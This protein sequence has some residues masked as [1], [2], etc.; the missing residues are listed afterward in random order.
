MTLHDTFSRRHV[1]QTTALASTSIPLVGTAAGTT[2]EVDT[3]MEAFAGGSPLVVARGDALGF[4][5]EHFSSGGS[6]PFL[7]RTRLRGPESFVALVPRRL[8]DEAGQVGLDNMLLMTS[9]QALEGNLTT[10]MAGVMYS[11]SQLISDQAGGAVSDKASPKLFPDELEATRVLAFPRSQ[12]VSPSNWSPEGYRGPDPTDSVEAGTSLAGLAAER[13]LV[14]AALGH[15]F[16][17]DDV[18]AAVEPM[19]WEE[20]AA[21]ETA[22]V[23][24]PGD[25]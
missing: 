25:L 15:Q 11:G 14:F 17:T 22:A 8:T 9:A 21:T 12:W 13:A 4:T 19:E 7:Q 6:N 2:Q 18:A 10:T 20:L 24:L 23:L 16:F 5:D 3:F 1:L